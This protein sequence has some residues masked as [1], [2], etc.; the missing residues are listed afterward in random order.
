MAVCIEA[1]MYCL[2]CLFCRD[3]MSIVGH[4]ERILSYVQSASAFG[5]FKFC[6]F[7]SLLLSRSPTPF[8]TPLSQ[9]DAIA[10]MNSSLDFILNTYC[11]GE[12]VPRLLSSQLHFAL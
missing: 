2:F 9:S 6:T 3:E 10:L 5:S 7:A 1:W 8:A 11:S 12:F 4:W